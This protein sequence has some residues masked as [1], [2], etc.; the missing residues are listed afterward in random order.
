M[1]WGALAIAAAAL[2]SV[3]AYGKAP[4]PPEP[5]GHAPAPAQRAWARPAV[6]LPMLPSLGRVRVE[7]ARDHVTVLE[8]VHLPRGDW[9]SG[10]L[11]LYVA[12]GSPGTPIAI[13]ARLVAAASGAT[14]LRADDAG[15]PLTVESA[16]H[17]SA[18]TQLLLGPAHMAGVVVHVKDADLRRAYAIADLAGVR[19]RSLLGPPATDPSGERAL[20]VRLGAAGGLPITLGRIQMVSL[21]PPPW[22]QR[23]EATLCGPDADARP[24]ALSVLPKPVGPQPAGAPPAPPIAPAMAVRHASDDL[25]IRW[26]A[27]P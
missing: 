15:D 21:E 19:L 13:D 4:T 2:S 12:F 23:V 8:D 7:V 10:G 11:D 27:A 16:V 3:D 25:C 22:I 9:Q 14:E 24:L 6:P 26:W 5:A 17:P 18:S 1:K 20:V